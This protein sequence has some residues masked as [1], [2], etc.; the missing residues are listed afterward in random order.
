MNWTALPELPKPSKNIFV[1]W[2]SSEASTTATYVHGVF[3]S[4]FSAQRI[5]SVTHWCE[6]TKPE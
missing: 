4:L 2:L 6:I 5:N 1:V 3:Y